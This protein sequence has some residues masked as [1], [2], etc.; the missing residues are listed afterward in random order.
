VVLIRTVFVLSA[1]LTS[2]LGLLG[3]LGQKDSLDV[4]QDTSLGNGDTAEKLVQLLVITDGQLQV[5]GDDP[6]LLV[7]TGSI[8]CQLK[9]LSGQVF[10]HGSQV[11]WGTSTNTLGIVALAEMTVDTSDWEL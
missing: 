10:H 4:G 8:A 9:N 3:L 7:V 5:T 6:C 2:L 11:D 1:N